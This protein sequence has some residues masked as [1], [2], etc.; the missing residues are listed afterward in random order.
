MKSALIV[1]ATSAIAEETTRKLAAQGSKLVLVGRNAERLQTQADDLKIRGAQAVHTLILDLNNFEFH[2]VTWRKSL[3]LL[4]EIDLVLVMTVNP[5]FGGQSFIPGQL[6]K[7]RELRARIDA[8]GR[9]IDLEVD[10]GI[11]KDTIGLA[12]KAGADTFVAGS[13]IFNTENY[14][15]TISELRSKIN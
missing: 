1:G 14:E 10:G 3:G 12:S 11:N 15:Q 13:A 4:G 5:G 2:E 7:I 6:D 8:S 9:T